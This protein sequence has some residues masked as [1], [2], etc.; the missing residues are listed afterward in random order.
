MGTVWRRGSSGPSRGQL[1]GFLV[2]TAL[3]AGALALAYAPL[4]L[5]VV[6]AVLGAGSVLAAWLPE[7]RRDRRR[8]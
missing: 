4:W 2:T 6:V 1:I 3:V 7:W 5:V 8:S